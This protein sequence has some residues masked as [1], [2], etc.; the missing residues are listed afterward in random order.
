M[1]HWAKPGVQ[2]VCIDADEWPSLHAMGHS[3][4]TRVPMLHE[5]LTVQTVILDAGRIYL[6]FSEIPLRQFDGPL[7]ADV[8]WAASSFRPLTKRPTD[9]SVFTDMLT[10][11]PKVVVP[12]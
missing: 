11:A 2:C 6:T 1:T 3:L 12:A 5:V 8:I 10:P 9:I 7:S 4:P